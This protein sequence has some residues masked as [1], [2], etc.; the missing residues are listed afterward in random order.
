MFNSVIKS[1]IDLLKLRKDA[2]KTDLEIEKLERERKKAESRI[3]LASFE[4]VKRFDPNVRNLINTLPH[5]AARKKSNPLVII[6]VILIIIAIT[7]A[8]AFYKLFA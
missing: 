4:D 6:L 2:K 3:E 8:V 5:R 7:I 1:I